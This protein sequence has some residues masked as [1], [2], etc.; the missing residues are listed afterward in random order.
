MSESST[1][2]APAI[3]QIARQALDAFEAEYWS[4]RHCRSSLA[5]APIEAVIRH[6]LPHAEPPSPPRHVEVDAEHHRLYGDALAVWTQLQHCR[7]SFEALI[8]FL[9]TE[10][11]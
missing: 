2:I 9:R 10:I 5:A 3:D 7:S 6:L 11:P 8:H 4:G 1:Q